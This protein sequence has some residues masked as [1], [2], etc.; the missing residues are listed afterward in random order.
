M[1]SEFQGKRALVTGGNKGIGFAICQG[2]LRAGFEVIIAA[3]SLDKAKTAVQKL[4][5]NA[6]VR[7]VELDVTDDDSI[8]R[9]AEQLNQDDLDVLVNNA[10][11]YPDQDTNILNISRSTLQLALN[12]NTFGAIQV[13]Q[14]FLP[15]LQ[16]AT[17]A[18]VINVSSGY[19]ELSGLSAGVPSYCLSKLALNGAT[20]MLAEALQAQGIAVYAMCPGW[21]KTDMGGKNAPRSPEQGADT[22][23]WLATEASPDLSGK[24][25][26]DRQE[27]SY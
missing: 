5:A 4:P 22:A 20:I 14:A 7:V 27:I 26:R 11:V 18:R 25:F 24:F 23:I 6:S 16:K 21:V 3:R 19:G 1:N 15:L 9:A 17:Q 8:H 13:T 12:T 10:G 2:L